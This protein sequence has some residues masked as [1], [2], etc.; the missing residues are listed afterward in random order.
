MENVLSKIKIQKLDSLSKDISNFRKSVLENDYVNSSLNL[1][2]NDSNIDFLQKVNQ[3]KYGIFLKDK[4]NE[5]M[6]NIL[7][8]MIQNNI[9]IENI[10]NFINSI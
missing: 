6:S 2:V 9:V 7:L 8:Y 1:T 3:S 5:I 4:S 10:K